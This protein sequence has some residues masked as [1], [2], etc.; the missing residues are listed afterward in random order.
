MKFIL[1]EELENRMY[2]NITEREEHGRKGGNTPTAESRN[3]TE[4]HFEEE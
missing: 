2:H 4:E 3:T 1:V